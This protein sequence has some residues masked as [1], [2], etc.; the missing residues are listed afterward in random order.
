MDGDAHPLETTIKAD[1]ADRLLEPA[2]EPAAAQ[3]RRFAVLVIVCFLAHAGLIAML[4]RD[5]RPEDK[6]LQEQE[7]PIEVVMLPPPEE[8]P[9][10]KQQPTPPVDLVTPP[11]VKPKPPPEK[12]ELED[13]E[14]AHDAPMA[15]NAA[16]T[17]K[18]APETETAAPRVA[19]P[20]KL[21]S[22]ERAEDKP[23]QE[24]AEAPAEEAPP[25]PS[26][27]PKVA[28]ANPDA[29][30]LDKAQPPEPPARPKQKPTPKESKKPPTEG[31]KLTVAQ[32]LAALSPSQNFALGSKAKSAP[33]AGGT[34]KASY[35]SLLFG[36]IKRQMRFPPG[37]RG[38]HLTGG[39]MVSLYV[40]EMGHLTHQAVYRASGVPA[41][42][43]AWLA[44]IR[45][46]APFPA[47]PRGLPH[48]FILG[49]PVGSE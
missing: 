37:L 18:G 41:L 44:A 30:P 14:E 26:E 27:S 23:E 5:D 40:D 16:T 20:P 25:E 29:E 46:A 42:D 10:Q 49:Y 39:G 43:A 19:P 11:I 47:P 17:E 4:L 35:E 24:K 32:Q 28:E 22:P 15:A 7:I 38:R 34:D 31:K 33:I 13:V 36:L 45:R 1:P 6:P 2:A 8:L 21:L 48:A 9:A 3:R 12:V